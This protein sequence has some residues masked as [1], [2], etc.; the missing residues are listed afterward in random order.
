MINEHKLPKKHVRQ[1]NWLLLFVIFVLANLQRMQPFKNKSVKSSNP[2]TLCSS[3]SEIGIDSHQAAKCRF[4]RRYPSAQG[5]M[6]WELLED[7]MGLRKIIRSRSYP[8]WK[9]DMLVS[10]LRM[11]CCLHFAQI[12]TVNDDHLDTNGTE[13]FY[14]FTWH[15]CVHH[16]RWIIS[17]SWDVGQADPKDTVGA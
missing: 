12:K 3:R 2:Q 1:K 17:C 4:Q 7:P 8:L 14:R 13:A 15:I 6:P 11:L 16:V 5:I 9:R 10:S